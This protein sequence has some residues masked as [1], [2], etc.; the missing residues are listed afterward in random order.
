MLLSITSWKRRLSIAR[1]MVRVCFPAI[2]CLQLFGCQDAPP[3]GVRLGRVIWRTE[4]VGH[5]VP[6]FD[7]ATVYFLGW[8]HDVTAVDKWTGSIRWKRFT[9]WPSGMT[10][11][12]DVVVAG[13]IVAVAD[14]DIYAFDKQTGEQRWMFRPLDDYAGYVGLATDGASVFGGSTKNRAYAIDAASGSLRWMTTVTS[15]SGT[16]VSYPV[17]GGNLVYY[18]VTF[19]NTAL[20]TGAVVALD[21]GSGA[22]RWRRD[23]PAISPPRAAGCYMRVAV[24]DSL[25]IASTDDGRLYALRPET[26]DSVWMA[27]APLVAGG[28]EKGP[29]AADGPTQIAAGNSGLVRAYD[30]RTGKPLWQA[31]A[32]QGSVTWPIALR[33]DRVFVVHAGAQ[34]A[35]FETQSGRQLWVEGAGASG[36]GEYN[37][38]QRS[39]AIGCT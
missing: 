35:A 37:Y 14:V 24:T 27:E 19:L 9:P 10:D 29:I 34:L 8:N 23:F 32:D 12:Y 26:G 33:G 7:E 15:D 39:T 31:S 5:G 2:I 21:A 38:T 18:C 4:G 36:G 16:W 3:S 22:L 13:S 11:G 25:V 20:Y 30:V 1:S 28:I 17:T 6:A